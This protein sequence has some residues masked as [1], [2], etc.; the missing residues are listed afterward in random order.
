MSYVQTASL[1]SPRGKS[2]GIVGMPEGYLIRTLL[3]KVGTHLDG[4]VIEAGITLPSTDK[5]RGDLG[6]SCSC[7]GGFRPVDRRGRGR[8]RVYTPVRQGT[9]WQDRQLQTVVA[10][11][12][13]A[14]DVYFVD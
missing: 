2:S 7:G 8:N 3:D 6:L 1:F 13:Q 9:W 11:V 14:N 4:N 5:P 10:F 12:M